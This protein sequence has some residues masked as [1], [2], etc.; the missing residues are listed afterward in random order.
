MKTLAEMSYSRNYFKKKAVCLLKVKYFATKSSLFLQEGLLFLQ[1][2]IWMLKEEESSPAS[3]PHL[4][5][6]HT[7]T[8]RIILPAIRHMDT[9]HLLRN[10]CMIV[11]R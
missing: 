7:L 5:Q 4:Q 11:F 9:K 6:T 2:P 8:S 1:S 3:P 10:S